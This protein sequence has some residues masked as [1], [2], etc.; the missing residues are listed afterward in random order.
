MKDLVKYLESHNIKINLQNGN[1]VVSGSNSE[2]IT[3][4]IKSNKYLRIALLS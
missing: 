4:E 1:I 3:N 2:Q